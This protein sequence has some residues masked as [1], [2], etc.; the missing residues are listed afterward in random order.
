MI[1]TVEPFGVIFMDIWLPGEV[2][3]KFDSTKLLLILWVVSRLEN[4]Y[5][6]QDDTS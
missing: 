4:W 5:Q 6:I 1:Y 2:P 3:S